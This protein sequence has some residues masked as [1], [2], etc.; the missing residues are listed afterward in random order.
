MRFGEIYN[1]LELTRQSADQYREN[2]AR[3]AV[4][5]ARYFTSGFGQLVGTEIRFENPF[6]HMPM[7]Q[8]G[9]ELQVSPDPAI[10]QPP[11]CSGGVARW[12]MDNN[13]ID[14]VGFFPL[15]SV[16][17]LPNQIGPV[18]TSEMIRE[19]EELQFGN[20]PRVG[21]VHHFSFRGNAY[22]RLP[23]AIDN[24]LLSG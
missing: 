24:V 6:T 15:I 23:S 18:V 12:V 19:H 16:H 9:Y 17:V 1:E 22:K 10:W 4:A 20:P 14:Y 3:N 13:G 2:S 8:Y 21:V 7:V 11:R 5:H